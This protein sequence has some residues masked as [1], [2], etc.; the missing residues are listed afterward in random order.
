MTATRSSEAGGRKRQVNTVAQIL[1][2]RQQP[3][4][5]RAQP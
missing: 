4:S 5:E 1:H 3:G 2:H